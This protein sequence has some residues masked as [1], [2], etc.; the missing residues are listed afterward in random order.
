MPADRLERG[1]AGAQPVED[2]LATEGRVRPRVAALPARPHRIVAQEPYDR[3]VDIREVVEGS[4]VAVQEVALERVRAL[5]GGRSVAVR[6][7]SELGLEQRDAG[8][9]GMH[10]VQGGGAYVREGS[11]VP[12][13]VVG[14][15]DRVQLGVE[16]GH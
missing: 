16:A 2:P 15:A 10:V 14:E 3:A 5:L 11:P 6:L 9:A 13:D 1:L 12:T 7:G 4:Q 8:K